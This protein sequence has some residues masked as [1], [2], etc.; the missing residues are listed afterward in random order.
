MTTCF[1]CNTPHP[2]PKP[3]PT[4]HPWPY[5]YPY[6]TPLTLSLTPNP[7]PTPH[8]AMLDQRVSPTAS[9]HLFLHALTPFGTTA[10]TVIKNFEE[11]R[12]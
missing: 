9:S 6:P 12:P 10:D 8:Q 2:S 3:A 1:S 7:I 5:P 11:V 4:P